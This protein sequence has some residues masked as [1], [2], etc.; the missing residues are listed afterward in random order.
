MTEEEIMRRTVVLSSLLLEDFDRLEQAGY[1]KQ[2]LK[3]AL[4]ISKRETEAYL[5]RIFD[6]MDNPL[7]S[8]IYVEKKGREISEL[9]INE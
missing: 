7:P 2:R 3:Q 5:D 6:L 1:A 9:F 4:K 8:A